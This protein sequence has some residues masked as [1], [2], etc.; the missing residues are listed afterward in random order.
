VPKNPQPPW[1]PRLVQFRLKPRLVGVKDS[2][3]ISQR[4]QFIEHHGH[5]A[6]HADLISSI[7]K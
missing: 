2:M 4:L 5:V 7:R 1:S 6:R 3:P